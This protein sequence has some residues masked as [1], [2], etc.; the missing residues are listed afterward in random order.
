MDK[1][2][3]KP[4]QRFKEGNAFV[5][6]AQNPIGQVESSFRRRLGKNV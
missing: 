1:I 5:E 3:S 6:I 2:V 4:I